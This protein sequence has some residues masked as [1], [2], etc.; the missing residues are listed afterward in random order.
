M[1][2]GCYTSESVTVDVTSVA[3]IDSAMSEV[4]V[5]TTVTFSDATAGGIWSSSSTAIATIGSITGLVTGISA[6]S[7]YIT[8]TVTGV[9]GP[10]S[11]TTTVY[12]SSTTSAGAIS[13]P[14]VAYIGAP[15]ITLTDWASPGIWS[16]GS[17]AIASVGSATGVVTAVSA[18]T[19]TIS[20][21]VTGCGG[22]AVATTVVTVSSLDGI[23]GHVRFTSGGYPGSVKVWLITYNPLSSDLEAIDSTIATGSDTDQY[24]QFIGIAT[25]SFRI[26]AGP[27]LDT[28]YLGSSTTGYIPTYHDTSFYW[29]DATVLYHV[30]GT[31]DLNQDINMLSGTLIS[32]PGFIAGNVLTGAN[33]GTSGSIPVVG[34][35]MAVINTTTNTIA[36]MAFTDAGGNYSFSNLPYG[37][38]TVF[39]DSVNY[40]TT[41]ITGITLSAASPSFNT[42]AFTQHTLA[43]T[44][45][46]G[47]EAIKNLSSVSSVTAFPNPTKGRLNIMWNEKTTEKA[48][49]V[50]SDITGR[51]VYTSTLTLTSGN[52]ISPVD[53]S[54]LN[55][56]LYII[57]VK[58]ATLS[59]NNKIEIQH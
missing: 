50:I 39:P 58:T 41:P 49:L 59:Y 45:T 26:K 40:A 56:G 16:S 25:D 55:N 31:N 14:S 52:G 46:P 11:R 1:G 57:S 19:T 12:V 29:H 51:E 38:Y 43:K 6:G 13:G 5:G 18:G 23:S 4:C 28:T 53:L 2:P 36:G 54:A 32:G 22:T 15:P 42:A 27:D 48:S 30:S 20:Y 44:I 34:L 10:A 37:T 17:P 8:Y 24:Y 33:R 7:A 47:T 35:H 3:D 21:S 9:C